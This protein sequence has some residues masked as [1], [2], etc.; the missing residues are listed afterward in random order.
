MN[1]ADLIIFNAKVYTVDDNNPHAEAVAVRG[2]QIVFVGSNAEALAWRGDATRLVDGQGRTLLPG[3]IDSHYHLMWGSLRLGHVDLRGLRTLAEVQTA[4]STYNTA[5]PD[6]AWL[7][8]RGLRYDVAGHEPLN[9]HHL[10]IIEKERP[11]LITAYDLHTIWANTVALEKAGLLH[12]KPNLSGSAAVVMGSD[13]LAT[14]ELREPP[15]YDPLLALLPEPDAAQKQALLKMG[16]AEA[17]TFGITSIHNMDGD[18]AQA[19]LYAD[20]EATGD[21]SL[22]V[23]IPYSIDPETPFA[24]VASEAVALRDQFQST[25]V[26]GGCVKFFMDGVFESY[27]AVV[28]NDYPDQPGN[29]GEPIFDAEHF[30]AMATEADRLGLQ[31]FVHACGDGAVRQVLDGYETAMQINGRRDSRHRVE[32]IE[33]IHPDDLP[34]F[35]QL[36]VVASM[37]PLHAPQP[38][39]SPD[40]WPSRIRPADWD[41]AFAWRTL[42]D[43]GAWLAF[44]SDWPV[45]TQNPFL[46]LA[47][48]VARQPWAAGGR[49]HTITLAETIAAYTRNAAYAEFQED[50]K[51][52]IKVGMWADLVLLSTD[53]FALPPQELADVSAVLTVCDG[54]VVYERLAIG[55]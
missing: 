17:A 25:M 43:G 20:L 1:Q 55:D 33:L 10:D 16:L 52:Q 42:S 22:R 39:I 8:G 4:V 18:A 45:V 27:S 38:N 26:R 2:N 19:Q 53:I 24:A 48:A 41:R 36:G 7:V 6:L 3:F 21:L 11:F 35:A 44:G 14:G 31:I 47:A 34:R 32:H 5:N 30:A 49:D 12:G 37:Q 46:G 23:Y 15:A 40:V 50:K 29:F 28:V 9:R 13:G 54:R 51:G